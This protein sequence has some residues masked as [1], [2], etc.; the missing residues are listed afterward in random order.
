MG[1]FTLI[2]PHHVFTSK[3]GT[4]PCFCTGL[5]ASIDEATDLR[6]FRSPSQTMDAATLARWNTQG[7]HTGDQMAYTVVSRAAW[8][9]DVAKNMVPPPS[10]VP[11]AFSAW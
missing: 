3:P 10:P 11:G 2:G 1:G 7:A 5:I 8:D 4:Q 9:A 6:L